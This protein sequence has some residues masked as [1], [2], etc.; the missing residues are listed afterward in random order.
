M[1]AYKYSASQIANYFSFKSQS[2]EE[3][4]SNLKLQKLVYYAQGL[5]IVC[6]G[7]PLYKEKI[8]AWKYGPVVP[9]L[10]HAYKRYG[11]SGVP[12]EDNFSPESIDLDTREF[13][14]EIYTVFGQFSAFRLMDSTH[15]D[16]CWQDA[17][18]DKIITHKSMKSALK[19]YLQDNAETAA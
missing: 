18:P 3:L 15:Q 17:Y 5:H 8:K 13:L 16:K 2:D 10:Y 14:N 7:H 6:Y 4:P 12:P 9:D 1:A 11:A 19:K